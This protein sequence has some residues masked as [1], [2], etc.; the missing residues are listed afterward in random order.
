M[1][2]GSGNGHVNWHEKG[3]LTGRGKGHANWKR[4]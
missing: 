3:I 2:T 4:K 1:L